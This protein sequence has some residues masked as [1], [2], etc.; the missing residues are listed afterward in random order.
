VAG[1]RFTT[2]IEDGPQDV[3]GQA[4]GAP[5][6]RHDEVGQPLGEDLPPAPAHP[7][8]KAAHAQME[9]D[10]GTG[11]GEV[12]DRALVLGVPSLGAAL[13]EGAARPVPRADNLQMEG[14]PLAPRAFDPHSCHPR[15]EELGKH[16]RLDL[17]PELC[18]LWSLSLPLIPSHR[19]CL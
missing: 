4:R 16:G 9:D 19:E 12:S 8:D 5:R 1:P 15:K 13:A 7:T 2:Q 18:G 17:S 11:T 14:W 10:V 3:R 6:V